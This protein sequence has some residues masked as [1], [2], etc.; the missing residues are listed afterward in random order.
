[1]L[2]FQIKL[3]VIYMRFSF[4]SLQLISGF[5][6]IEEET[7]LYLNEELQSRLQPNASNNSL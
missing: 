3:S 2:L 4:C 5:F 7:K 6:D 1:M